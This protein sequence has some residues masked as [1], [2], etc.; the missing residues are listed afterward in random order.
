MNDPQRSISAL[1]IFPAPVTKK[2]KTQYNKLQT[3]NKRTYKK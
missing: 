3:I 1:Y 2:K